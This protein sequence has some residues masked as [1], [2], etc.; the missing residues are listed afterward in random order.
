MNKRKK[1]ITKNVRNLV[2][3]SSKWPSLV[4]L[5]RMRR[6]LLLGRLLHFSPTSDS[7]LGAAP[8]FK[9]EKWG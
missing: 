8:F 9:I 1:K 2:G 6:S 4:G 7:E 5:W 3:S